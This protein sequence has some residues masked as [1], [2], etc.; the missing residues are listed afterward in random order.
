MDRLDPRRHPLRRNHHRQALREITHHLERHAARPDDDRRAKFR[1][2]N[3]GRTEQRS[4][5]VPAAQMPRQPRAVLAETAEIDDAFDPCAAGRLAED[6]RR[7]T[8]APG[9]IAPRVAH[10]MDQVVRDAAAAHR[11]EQ[12]FAVEHVAR[13]DLDARE[14]VGQ[15]R[16]VARETAHRVPGLRERRHEPPA[17]VAGRAGN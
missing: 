3:A 1:H 7:F 5:L 17:D 2:G 9:K 11:G 15:S 13:G 6:R 14:T 10:R 8:V 12:A 16:S 4:D